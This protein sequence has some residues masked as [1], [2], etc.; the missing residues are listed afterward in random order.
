MRALWE[1]KPSFKNNNRGTATEIRQ[2]VNEELRKLEKTIPTA[3]QPAAEGDKDSIKNE[4]NRITKSV[5][6]LG[7]LDERH[8]SNHS[9]DLLEHVLSLEQTCSI[10]SFNGST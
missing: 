3:W 9:N 1:R 6:K 5:G 8:L 10:L 4:I 2:F 7:V